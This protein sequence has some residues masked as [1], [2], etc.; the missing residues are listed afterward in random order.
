[1]CEFSAIHNIILIFCPIDPFRKFL[2]SEIEK[3]RKIQKFKKQLKNF[4]KIYIS[5]C[6]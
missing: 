5:V 1:M 3:F 2:V 6:A 4:Q